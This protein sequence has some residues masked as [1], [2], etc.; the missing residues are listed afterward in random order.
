MESN[1]QPLR[2]HVSDCTKDLLD[3]FQTFMFKSRGQVNLKVKFL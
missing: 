1:G 3:K 2:I